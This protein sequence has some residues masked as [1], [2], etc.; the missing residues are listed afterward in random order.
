M[1]SIDEDVEPIHDGHEN[2]RVWHESVELAE[3]VY[4]L[5]ANHPT[6]GSDG[7]GERMSETA[8]SI[9]SKIAA[10]RASG[11]DR[12]FRERL[13]EAAQ[14]AARFQ[15]QLSIL[16]RLE[17]VSEMRAEVLDFKAAEIARLIRALRGSLENRTGLRRKASG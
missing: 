7:F 1:S 12:R 9:P 5:V 17:L 4:R 2:L 13:R 3:H 10:G 14:L 15:S 6:L 8:A 16:R 11:D